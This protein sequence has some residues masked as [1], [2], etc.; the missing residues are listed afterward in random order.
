MLRKAV[1]VLTSDDKKRSIYV[2]SK[3]YKLI[4]DYIKSDDRHIKKF[5][6]IAHIILAGLRNTEVYDKEDFEG[7]AKNITAMKFFKGQENDRIYC[8]EITREDRTFVIIMG[9]L[10]LKKKNTKLSY[11]EKNI[12]RRIAGYVYELEE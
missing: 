9:E 7:S 1:R 2:D 12:I 5:Q 8:K 4:L 6:F 10:H 3:N 11:K